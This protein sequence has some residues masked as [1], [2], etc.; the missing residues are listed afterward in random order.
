MRRFWNYVFYFTW[1]FISAAG[2]LFTKPMEYLLYK[3]PYVKKNKEINEYSYDVVVK[4][5]L[6]GVN[7]LFA[8]RAMLSTTSIILLNF[9][10]F[11]SY[12]FDIGFVDCIEPWFGK[13]DWSYNVWVAGVVIVLLTSVS[14]EK[15]LKWHSNGYVKFF[16]EF[17]MIESKRKGYC[18]MCLFHVLPFLLLICL[19]MY[20]KY[21]GEQ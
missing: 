19:I 7:I 16:E 17:A 15:L 2:K 8:Y 6:T 21:R 9:I 10:L 4:N 1:L 12:T 3:I 11:I 5:Q 18:I 13:L 20:F 14:N